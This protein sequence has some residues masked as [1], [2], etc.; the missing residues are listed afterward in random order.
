LLNFSNDGSAGDFQL[1][2]ALVVAAVSLHLGK[3]GGV[4][5]AIGCFSQGVVGPSSGLQEF[6]EPV[7]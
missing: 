3:G 5:E 4:V 2:M 6:D 1:G 7:R